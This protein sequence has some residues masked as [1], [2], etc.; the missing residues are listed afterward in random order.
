MAPVTAAAVNLCACWVRFA[1]TPTPAPT[2]SEPT[3]APT[4]ASTPA[5]PTLA[6][7]PAPTPSEPTTSPAAGGAADAGQSTTATPRLPT[8]MLG[9]TSAATT[10]ERHNLDLNDA[11]G[12]GDNDEH[13]SHW[14]MEF[15]DPL[16][17]GVAVSGLAVGLLLGLALRR[18]GRDRVARDRAVR[19]LRRRFGSCLAPLPRPALCRHRCAVSR[20][21]R[22]PHAHRVL[23]IRWHARFTSLCLG[24]IQ[25]RLG[26][27][28]GPMKPASLDQDVGAE[29]DPQ[30]TWPQGAGLT[31]GARR[32]AAALAKLC[33]DSLDRP[34]PTSLSKSGR[35]HP[36]RAYL[37]DL[38]M[39]NQAGGGALDRAAVPPTAKLA[40]L[41]PPLPVMPPP[42]PPPPPQLC[43][44]DA[45]TYDAALEE[46]QYDAAVEE[47]QYEVIEFIDSGGAIACVARGDTTGTDC[48]SGAPLQPTMPDDHHYGN[49]E[50]GFDH[51]DHEYEYADPRGTQRLHA[52]QNGFGGNS[53]GA[54]VDDDLYVVPCGAG[55]RVRSRSDRLPPAPPSQ[56]SSED[57]TALMFAKISNGVATISC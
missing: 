31:S 4:P 27:G 17:A 40:T 50:M 37:H 43:N 56:W 36:Y 23:A 57:H 30:M 41:P 48:D 10:A 49:K 3:L 47:P 13:P 25:G 45:D 20:A 7:T 38:R 2:P 52:N 8:S 32:G 18:W 21:L 12:D 33:H 11:N 14:Y 22:S 51:V 44:L 39:D 15:K 53:S 16:V 35:R 46:P 24:W 34:M 42:L 19:Q 1:P 26:H 28:S 54:D 5:E 9:S 55:A 29:C 6:H